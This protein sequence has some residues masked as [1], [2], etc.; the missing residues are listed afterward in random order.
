M[1][2]S[3]LCYSAQQ[4]ARLA[5]QAVCIFYDQPVDD[6]QDIGALID[7]LHPAWLRA[8]QA[9]QQARHL[10]EYSG[11]AGATGQ[12]EPATSDECQDAITLAQNVVGWAQVILRSGKTL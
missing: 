2:N 7:M 11:G 4:A 1:A 8:P 3:A 5:L 12:A 6:S 9:V 10:S